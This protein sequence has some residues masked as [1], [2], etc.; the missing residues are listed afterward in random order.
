MVPKMLASDSWFRVLGKR[1]DWKDWPVLLRFHLPTNPGATC[2]V[3]VPYLCWSLLR[4]GGEL[5]KNR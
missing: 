4:L 3:P 1:T 5:A 2:H